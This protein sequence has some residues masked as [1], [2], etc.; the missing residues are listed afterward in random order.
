M[1]NVVYGVSGSGKTAYLME[2]IKND[3]NNKKRCF[4]LVPE[5]QAYISEFDVPRLLPSNARLYFEVVHFSGLADKIFHKYGGATQESLSQGMRKL[6][7]WETLRSMAP[8]LKE[9][10][11]NAAKDAP[12]AGF[13]TGHNFQRKTKSVLS[14][15]FFTNLPF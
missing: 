11:S 15:F 10:K 14:F 8:Q 3:I 5:Q 9:Y 2:Q 6:L 4:L 13:L 1:L 12:S 7:M